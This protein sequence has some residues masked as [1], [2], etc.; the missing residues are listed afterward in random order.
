MTIICHLGN[1]KAYSTSI[2]TMLAASGQEQFQYIGFRPSPDKADWYLNPLIAELLNFDLRYTTKFH[3][4]QKCPE[5]QAYFRQ[6]TQQAELENKD[7]W[8]SSE[9]L[10]MRAIMEEID[11][12]EKFARLQQ[13]L[14][15][16]VTFVLIFRN[17]WAS[18]RSL[19][20]EFTKM[21]YSKSFAYFT[22]EA[23]LFR[24]ANFLY[25][26]LP[27]HLLAALQQELTGTNRIAYHF[28]DNDPAVSGEKLHAFLSG[29]RPDTRLKPLKNINSSQE[30]SGTSESRAASNSQAGSTLDS[31][32]LIE[33]HRAFWH[34]DREHQ[35]SLDRHIWG[36]LRQNK[37]NNQTAGQSA[38]AQ[39][40]LSCSARL[41]AFIQD[42]Y[43]QDQALL[44]D[45]AD[46]DY[47]NLWLDLSPLAVK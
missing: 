24:R 19:Y 22:D 45:G 38:Q 43:P 37:K 34:L 47:H 5:Y 40:K 42:I 8:I 36:K 10:S 29:L 3:F 7:I 21:G 13:V 44:A 2:Q 31:S 17:I 32:G 15:D 12:Q 30:K 1:P 16:G 25:S 14:P 11:P 39:E 46:S 20:S 4:G 26:L 41:T 35:Q 18:L 6:L 28:L 23:Y 33:N 27:G 9:N